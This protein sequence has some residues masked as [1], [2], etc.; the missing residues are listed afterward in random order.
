MMEKA[1]GIQLTRVPYESGARVN[2]ALL[3]EHIDSMVS[4]MAWLT[5]HEGKLRPLVSASEERLASDLPTFKEMG[6][7]VICEAVNLIFLRKGVPEPVITLLRNK[8]APIRNNEKLKKEFLTQDQDP[9]VFDWRGCEELAVE[10]LM[11]A[12]TP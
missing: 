5:V 3:G 9:T 10:D 12:Q 8:W 4:N 11:K 6:Y 7:D 1:L 2:T